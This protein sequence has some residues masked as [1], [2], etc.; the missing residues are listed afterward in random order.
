MLGSSVFFLRPHH[1]HKVPHLA[2]DLFDVATKMEEES[3]E[4]SEWK[5][6][7]HNLTVNKPLIPLKITM[8]LYYGGKLVVE[9][10]KQSKQVSMGFP[11]S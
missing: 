6:L 1:H 3:E 5:K 4:V 7:K 2:I 8:L 10:T 9:K 11:R